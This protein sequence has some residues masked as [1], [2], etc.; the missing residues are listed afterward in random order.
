MRKIW[1]LIP[2][3]LIASCGT[4][5]TVVKPK[6]KPK[7]TAKTPIKV[8]GCTD[9]T[10]ANYD[11]EAD[12]DDG[13]CNYEYITVND[14]VSAERIAQLETGMSK[15]EVAA[16]L[17]ATPFDLLHAN[18]TCEIYSYEYRHIDREFTMKDFTSKS[19]LTNGK[20]MYSPE[21][22]NFYVIFRDQKLESVITD[23]AKSQ[24]ESVICFKDNCE[25]ESNYIV[26]GGCTD[27]EAL[28]FNAEANEDDG[29]CEYE[30][31]MVIGCEDDESLNYN[32][33]SGKEFRVT[34]NGSDDMRD[35]EVIFPKEDNSILPYNM[36]SEWIN[37]TSS[38]CE[39]CPCDY[40][41]NPDYDPRRDCDELCIFD[42]KLEE[43]FV[44]GCTDELAVNYNKDANKD[45]GSCV[46]CPC[47]TEEYRYILNT[48]HSGRNCDGNPCIKI[49]NEVEEEEVVQEDDCDL[50]DLLDLD[51]NVLPSLVAP[52][53][54]ELDMKLKN[55]KDNE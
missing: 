17:N 10:A 43:T 5:T 49:M 24:L 6:P 21:S 55:I 37:S 25:S 28:N 51:L 1:I 14:F 20:E 8:K 31:A 36:V 27:T 13:S 32:M 48:N 19:M 34:K 30:T 3:F 26:C 15:V 23:D 40:I 46:H 4:K 12:I 18:E 11:S 47:D 16:T 2:L 50:C 39:Y 9:K 33:Y 41:V 35:W 45:D 22:K 44:T 53:N 29:S 7:T 38:D 42:P 54:L 52:V